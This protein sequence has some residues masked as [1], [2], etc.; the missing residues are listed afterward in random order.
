MN[1]NAKSTYII[2]PILAEIL[3]KQQH[4]IQLFSGG[5]LE[6]N[7]KAKLNGEVDFLIVRY[8]QAVE[9]RDPIIAI[10]AAKKSDIEGSFKQCAAFNNRLG[11]SATIPKMYHQYLLLTQQKRE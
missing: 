7:K 1:I 3:R 9:L 10:L 8:P 2:A 5:N 4:K 6:G 11:L